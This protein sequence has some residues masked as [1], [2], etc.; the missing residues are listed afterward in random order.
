MTSVRWTLRAWEREGRVYRHWLDVDLALEWARRYLAARDAG[1]DL[2]ASDAFRRWWESANLGAYAMRAIGVDALTAPLA[3]FTLEGPGGRRGLPVAPIEL[4]RILASSQKIIDAP[5]T[6]GPSMPARSLWTP[7]FRVRVYRLGA[8]QTDEE[9]PD[10]GARGLSNELTSAVSLV[11]SSEGLDTGRAEHRLHETLDA[12]GI[13]GPSD[14]FVRDLKAEG[15]FP[16]WKTWDIP[17]IRGLTLAVRWHPVGLD[18]WYEV[19]W[20]D[21]NEARL[22]TTAALSSRQRCEPEY[23]DFPE[24]RAPVFGMPAVAQERW[25]SVPMAAVPGA[26]IRDDEIEAFVRDPWA[27][28]ELYTD[29]IIERNRLALARI[30]PSLASRAGLVSLSREAAAAASSV[31]IDAAA[32]SNRD[33]NLAALNEFAT[34][35]NVVPVLGQIAAAMAST[36][37]N[38]LAA[39]GAFDL[40]EAQRAAIMRDA[41]APLS[42]SGSLSS[43][44]PKPPDHSCFV[45]SGWTRPTE[46]FPGPPAMAERATGATVRP[47]D[48]AVR[49]VPGELVSTATESRYD[50]IP[51]LPQR[52]L[53]ELVDIERGVRN[54][55][56]PPP[57]SS[58]S[59]SGGLAIAAVVVVGAG[60]AWLFS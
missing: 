19:V 40:P 21:S 30:D 53:F 11:I 29:A 34:T 22:R 60:L 27:W 20:C 48:P 1:D 4:G 51:P 55:Q 54:F 8:V 31:A 57:E 37:G 50:Y 9:S 14:T 32:R 39:F 16:A 58:E 44:L 10:K 18:G 42:I 5:K 59:G 56:P 41:I 13:Q 6:A 33:A 38:L 45:P 25:L 52:D 3:R 43:T 26:W 24:G 23:Y 36:F 28:L 35:A 17:Q 2:V 7:R 15:T 49:V 47:F 12:L 46:A